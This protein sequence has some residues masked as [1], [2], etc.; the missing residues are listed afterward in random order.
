MSIVT[1]AA[2]LAALK[3]VVDPHTAKDFVT[4]RQIRNLK[5]E[6]DEVAFDRHPQRS[7]IFGH[8]D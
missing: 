6:A 3:T 2:L 8:H 7:G 1:E 4:G 5:I